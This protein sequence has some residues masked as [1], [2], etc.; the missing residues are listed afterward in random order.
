M[1][2][3]DWLHMNPLGYKA[4]ADVIDLNMFKKDK[5]CSF[6]IHFPPWRFCCHCWRRAIAYRGIFKI[7]YD[8]TLHC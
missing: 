5:I 1:Q 4:M 2:T 8:A 7:N 6:L 3:T